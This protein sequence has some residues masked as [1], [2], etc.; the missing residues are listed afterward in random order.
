[1]TISRI[2]QMWKCVLIGVFGLLLFVIWPPTVAEAH[3][4]GSFWDCYDTLRA[5]LTA[6]VGLSM[7]A[8]MLSMGL[9]FVPVVGQGKGL[10][11]AITG[12]DLITG[13]ELNEYER[14]LGIVGPAGA[15]AGGAFAIGRGFRQFDNIADAGSAARGT[16]QG[17]TGTGTGS[18]PLGRPRDTDVPSQTGRQA[19][20]GTGTGAT[21]RPR[22]A[23]GGSGHTGRPRDV[24]N[25]GSHHLY[26]GDSLLHSPTRPNGVGKPHI[27]SSGN[28][29]P[30]NTG[31]IYK[32]R[33]VT[34][35]EHI[36]GGY[37]RGAKSNSPYTSFTPDNNIVGTYGDHVISLDISALRKAI[38]S[39]EVKDV[40][41]LSPK[42]IK[43]LIENDTRTTDFWKQRALNWTNRDQE[44]LIRGEI[45]S[46]FFR[47]SPME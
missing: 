7:F 21:G 4:C 47:I 44:F 14:I 30:A 28:L 29:N 12:R 37:R 13:Q 6:T 17:N 2:K 11:E 43:R 31:G 9:D 18:P 1:M 45:P 22:D 5:A 24:D 27:S 34:V 40:A 20:S 10:I 39:G 33:Q 26:R 8:V 16:R 23:D 32:G 36:L 35:T 25:P 41:I 46:R 3:N 19:D 38:R 15:L 42:Q